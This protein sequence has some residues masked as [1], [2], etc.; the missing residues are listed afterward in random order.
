L[1]GNDPPSRRASAERPGRLPRAYRERSR[2]A[3]A[4]RS[5]TSS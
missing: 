5:L 1:G 2:W 3:R 4:R